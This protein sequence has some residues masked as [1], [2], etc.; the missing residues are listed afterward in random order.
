MLRLLKSA[1]IA[2][3]LALSATVLAQSEDPSMFSDLDGKPQR[4]EDFT[5]DGNWRVV[6]IWAA[7]CHICNTEAQSYGEFHRAQSGKGIG[8]LGI[9]MDGAENRAAARQ[10]V[11][12]HD[13]PFPNLIAEPEMVSLFYAAMTQESLRGT[14]TFLVYDPGGKLV[15]AQAGAVTVEAI[16]KFIARQNNTRVAQ[17]P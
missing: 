11:Q 14:P 12:R 8:I 17:E 13:L 9:S 5:G 7:D 4:L 16:E 10:F 6:M 1:S 15:A 3:L 2:L